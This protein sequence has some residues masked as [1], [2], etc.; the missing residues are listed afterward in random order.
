MAWLDNGDGTVGTLISQAEA[1]V[2]LDGRRRSEYCKEYPV[3]PIPS[4]IIYLSL[5]GE[6]DPNLYLLDYVEQSTLKIP[7]RPIRTMSM[8]R[9]S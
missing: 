6:D 5:G 2:T 7:M 1:E 3:N 8:D 9:S 4:D